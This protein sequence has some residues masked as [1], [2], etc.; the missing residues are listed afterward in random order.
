MTH[1]EVLGIPVSLILDETPLR[2]RFYSLSRRLHPDKFSQAAADQALY[3]TRWTTLLNRAYQE[4]REPTSLAEYV[5]ELNGLGGNAKAQVPVDLA[6]SY[7]ELQDAL[8]EPG[9]TARLEGFRADLEKKLGATTEETKAI[10]REWEG[11]KD[12]VTL[13]RLQA[14]LTKSRYLRSMLADIAKRKAP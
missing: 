2:E 4:L 3:A 11:T 10:Q 12:R 14:V 13:T 7:F 1:F 8:S 6:E 9:G 5:L